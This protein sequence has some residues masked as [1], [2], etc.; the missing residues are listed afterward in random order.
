MAVQITEP[1]LAPGTGQ[2]E[3]ELPFL[4][5]RRDLQLLEVDRDGVR[6]SAGGVR[7][8]QFQL[9]LIAE[10]DLTQPDKNKQPV[11]GEEIEHVLH[12][13]FIVVAQAHDAV[14]EHLIHRIAGAD[15]PLIGEQFLLGSGHFPKLDLDAAG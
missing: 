10:G 14:P 5:V 6:R 7:A 4:S 11:S 2:R 1:D 15:E 13:R 9:D 8:G 12:H 3:R